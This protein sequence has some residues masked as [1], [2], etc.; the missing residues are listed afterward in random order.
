M[1]CKTASNKDAFRYLSKHR[2]SCP[3]KFSKKVFFKISQNSQENT[4]ARVFFNKDCEACNFIKKEA[5]AQVFFCEFGE[6]FI[7]TFFYRTPPV[8]TSESSYLSEHSSQLLPNF[9][10]FHFFFDL[11]FF[12]DY[13]SQSVCQPVNFNFLLIHSWSMFPFSNPWK[14]QKSFGFLVFS[15]GIKW[16]NVPEMN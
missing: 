7:N 13:I 10:H 11:G 4:C 16:K 3:E 8:A 2:S 15:G 14:Q 12:P 5:L 9:K 6:I 1:Y